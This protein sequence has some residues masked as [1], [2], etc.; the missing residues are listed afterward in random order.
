V[1]RT[2]PPGLLCAGHAETGND[3]PGILSTTRAERIDGGY[4]FTGHKAF[5]SLTP[6]WTFLGLHGMDTSDPAAP[7]IVHAFMPRTTKGYTIKETW[8]TLGMRATRSDDTILDGA[9]VP[10]QYIGRVVPAGFAGVDLFVLGIFAWALMGFG[11]IYYGLAQRACDLAVES[12]KSKKSLGMSRPM[13][14]HAEVQHG[15]AEM[16]MALEAIGPQ[17]EKT[18]QDWSGGVNHGG[19]WVIKLLAAKRLSAMPSRAPGR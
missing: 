3:L 5:G 2:A 9:F 7:K 8:D 10:D 11:N 12:L 18:A 1:S 4:R 16:V 6:V 14:Y 17:L 15:V 13:T 19:A